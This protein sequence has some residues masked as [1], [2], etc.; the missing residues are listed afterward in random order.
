MPF[1]SICFPLS[2]IVV[3]VLITI[4]EAL[5]PGAAAVSCADTT[6]EYVERTFFSLERKAL[7]QKLRQA[8]AELTEQNLHKQSHGH[9]VQAQSIAVAKARRSLDV[10]RSTISIYDDSTSIVGRRISMTCYREALNKL[11]AATASDLSFMHVMHLHGLVASETLRGSFRCWWKNWKVTLLKV[12]ENVRDIV[13]SAHSSTQLAAIGAD[14]PLIW[15]YRRSR[16]VGNVQ[17]MLA[18]VGVSF[19]AFCTYTLIFF[20]IPVW[21][22]YFLGHQVMYHVWVVG[23]LTPFLHSFA[24]SKPHLSPT[25]L[26]GD[27]LLD[28]ANFPSELA[29]VA[30][31]MTACL[32]ISWILMPWMTVLFIV[33]HRQRVKVG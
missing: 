19:V 27:I 31:W 18:I 22:V 11:D 5:D 6:E 25:A 26:I 7:E 2:I 4:A 17:F 33:P 24:D 12:K 3:L 30:L 20:A 28:F 9:D 29:L 10:A 21:V 15:G 16:V 32:A 1:H 13:M 8:E 23:I 14:E